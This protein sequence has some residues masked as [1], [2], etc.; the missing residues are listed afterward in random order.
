MHNTS[1]KSLIIMAV[2]A[3]SVFA[4]S[5]AFAT[6]GFFTHGSGARNKAMGG[7]G[8]ADSR[9]ATA[10]AIN[11]AGIVG[12]GDEVAIAISGFSP[13]RKFT[14]S[15]T[16]SFTPNG[17]VESSNNL[18]A[19]PNAVYVKQIDD[20]SAWAIGMSANGGMNTTYK[21]VVN[22]TCQFLVGQTPPQAP[23]DNGVFCGGDSGVNLNQALIS[24]GY[25]RDMGGLKI[26]VAPIFA[27][28]IF[29]ASGL[30]A[31]GGFSSSPTNLTNNESSKSTGFGAKIGA[32]YAVSDA[33][34]VAAS[35]QTKINMSEFDEYAGLFAD[36]GDFDIPS[37]YQIG[38][39][40]DFT[41]DFTVNLDYRHIKYSDNG[42]VSNSSRTQ[43]PF[44][45]DGGPGF[46]W[47]DIGAVKIGAEWRASDQWTWRAGFATNDQP[48][49]SED[50]TL[51]V[52]APGVVTKHITAGAAY[53]MD[54]GHTLEFAI[55]H[56]PTESVSGNEVIAAPNPGHFIKAEMS[57]LEVTLGWKYSF[58]N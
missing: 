16:P 49:Q 11:P 56:A 27:F 50:I 25:A 8:V 19:I 38:I 52:L 57:Q 29:K 39:S 28:Q 34:R 43:L 44:G 1:K 54:N 6:E 51:N 31:F 41:P 17:E 45:A 5:D 20:V 48:V 32:E 14:G 24:V 37:N 47:D 7:A 3:G 15:G 55:M 33:V 4:S 9:D 12:V 2:A 18:F 36:G 22:P 21:G 10:L 13:K 42:A 53:D 40:A 26:G 23:A 35:Y 58:G 30:S 46:G